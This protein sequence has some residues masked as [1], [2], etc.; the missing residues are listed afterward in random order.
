ML[1][2]SDRRSRWLVPLAVACAWHAVAIY[3]M[4]LWRG[5]GLRLP[6]ATSAAGLVAMLYLIHLGMQALVHPRRLRPTRLHAAI[7]APMLLVFALAFWTRLGCIETVSVIA[8]LQLGFTA[9]LLWAAHAGRRH[10]S[11]RGPLR[12]T[13]LL[14]LATM[15]HFMVR[16]P[17]EFF[18]PASQLLL[19]LR[20][21]TMVLVTLMA[22]SFLA[23][24][25]A[26]SRRRLH[27]ESRLDGLTGL[28][29]R[30]AMEEEAA[31]QVKVATRRGRPCAL[32]M[33]DL[34]NFKSLNDTWGHELGDRA[35]LAAG[36]LLIRAAQHCENFS[37]AR[38]GG[39][40]FAMLLPDCGVLAAYTL[41]ER[42][43]AD[44]AALRIYAGNK[45]VRFT[46][47]IGVSALQAGETGWTEML[48]RADVALYRAKHGGRNRV[49]L[50][51]DALC[52]SGQVEY[53]DASGADYAGACAS[54]NSET[55]MAT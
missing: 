28:R 24:Y 4:P 22:F 38:L 43:R 17:L 23:V 14:L 29:N 15:L 42:L 5:A 30:R 16:L 35:L 12:A 46:A 18:F 10:W 26:E 19:L 55:K 53:T 3:L 54:E 34:D 40:E 47:S 7:A 31:E 45:Q 9:R 49:V 6:Q 25:A 33:L 48:R 52:D 2:W 44:M 11:L 32:L 39:E 27:E 36:G 21:S 1:A 50:C 13:A 20:E 41:A 8:I 51:K 37:V